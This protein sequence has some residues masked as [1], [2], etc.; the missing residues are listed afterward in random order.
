MYLCY[1][2][3]MKHHILYFYNALFEYHTLRQAWCE[4]KFI[5]YRDTAAVLTVNV[6]LSVVDTVVSLSDTAAVLTV[7]TATH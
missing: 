3:K 6:Y 4:T 5:K 1:L 2:V 7:V